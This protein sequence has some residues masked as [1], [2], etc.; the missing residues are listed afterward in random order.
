MENNYRYLIQENGTH[1]TIA[2]F[3]YTSPTFLSLK[4]I[5]KHLK[6]NFPNVLTP[7]NFYCVSVY[8]NG[9][10]D[11]DC[12]FSTDE[13]ADVD[14]D[15][16]CYL[17][18]YEHILFNMR[19]DDFVDTI[20]AQKPLNLKEIRKRMKKADVRKNCPYKVRMYI[21]GFYEK[22]FKFRTNK[23]GNVRY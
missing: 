5:L 9:N 10:F 3:S 1:R 7:Y 2:D 21:N 8:K 11:R 15:D 23:N 6:E 12:I 13:D 17:Y 14:L 16:D 4:D 22:E 19:T 20:Y 18:P